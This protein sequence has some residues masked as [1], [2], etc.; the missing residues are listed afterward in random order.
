MQ[1]G[2]FSLSNSIQNQP[3]L[4]KEMIEVL[5]ILTTVV[6]SQNI[7]DNICLQK[8]AFIKSS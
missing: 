1:I 8:V 6:Y 4:A 7:N 3:L 2:E 5:C